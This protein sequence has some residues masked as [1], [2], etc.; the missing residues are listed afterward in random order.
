MDWKAYP[1]SDS[2]L[3]KINF[4][5]LCPR[6]LRKDNITSYKI[7]YRTYMPPKWVK[8]EINIPICKS[9][10]KTAIQKYRKQM[11]IIAM[12]W[13][14]LAWGLLLVL[15]FTGILWSIV[16]ALGFP[17]GLLLPAV[18]LLTP[19]YAL[20]LFIRSLISP[21]GL[22]PILIEDNTN[23][24]IFENEA[25]VKKFA[26]SNVELLRSVGNFAATP[27]KVL[28]EQGYLVKK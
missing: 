5:S 19:F 2:A 18:L 7:E 3:E 4:P 15:G 22:W 8:K 9:C 12:V 20:Y 23:A 25:Y 10:K 26:E 21:D 13:V 14:P 28:I 27:P 17:W 11:A 6:C 24:L 1:V 16:K